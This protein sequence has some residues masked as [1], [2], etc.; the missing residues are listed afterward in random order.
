VIRAAYEA[1]FDSCSCNEAQ[2][3]S[4]HRKNNGFNAKDAKDTQRYAKA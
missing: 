3:A 4:P 1:A 2:E